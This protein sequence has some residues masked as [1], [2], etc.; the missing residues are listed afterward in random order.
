MLE[1]YGG[2][3]YHLYIRIDILWAQSLINLNQKLA[4]HDISLHFHFF[5]ISFLKN[6]EGL[7]F[8]VT[9]NMKPYFP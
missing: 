7:I 6:K 2:S 5:P 4:V 9:C 3:K 8:H 1:K